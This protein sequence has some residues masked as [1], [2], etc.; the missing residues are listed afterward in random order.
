M[1]S[2]HSFRERHVSVAL[3]LLHLGVV[4]AQKL[5]QTYSALAVVK[6]PHDARST[7][8]A[9]IDRVQF[10][11]LKYS[12]RGNVDVPTQKLLSTLNAKLRECLAFR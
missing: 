6:S 9:A 2:L 5:R 8:T 12:S 7:L 4:V 3:E 11:R 10:G 1:E